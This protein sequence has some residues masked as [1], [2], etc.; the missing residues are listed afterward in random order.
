MKTFCKTWC[1][2]SKL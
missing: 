1:F 2:V